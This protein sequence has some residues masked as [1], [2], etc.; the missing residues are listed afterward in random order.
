M[1]AFKNIVSKKQSPCCLLKLEQ[2]LYTILQIL[3]ITLFEKTTLSQAFAKSNY[4]NLNYARYDDRYAEK[5][6]SMR[7]DYFAACYT[8]ECRM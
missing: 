7:W 5:T 6:L 1:A 8:A 4:I 3:S 2:S